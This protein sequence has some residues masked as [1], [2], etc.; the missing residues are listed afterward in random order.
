[1]SSSAA[2]EAVFALA[3]TELSGNT[4][5]SRQD[6]AQACVEA[7][8]QIAGAPTG[9]MDQAAVLQA[10]PGCALLVDASSGATSQVPFDLASH[11]LELLIIDTRAPHALVD[12]EYGLRRQTCERV[13]KL[14]GVPNLAQ[15][16][17]ADL[18]AAIAR[19]QELGSQAA[20][21]KRPKP[22][23]PSSTHP[24]PT[25]I[26]TRCLHHARL[27][28]LGS[29][30]APAE[31]SKAGAPSST[32]P[33]STDTE[34]RRLHHARLQELGSQ[35]APGLQ[36]EPG[37]PSSMHPS[38]MDIETRCLRHVVTEIDRTKQFVDLLSAGR[39][40]E[41]GPLLSASHASLRDDYRVSSPELDLAAATAEQA[42]ALGAR[43]VGG[44]FGGSA[45]ALVRAGSAPAIAR[46]VA[47][48][49]AKANHRPPQFL[50]ATPSPPAT[51]LT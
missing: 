4:Q 50:M 10:E 14:L 16:G 38:P 24:S 31:Q 12:S 13:A 7:E 45:L 49:F 44:G 35:A 40:E 3:S 23:A 34:R 9:G 47:H 21:A 43:M 2:L 28:E 19:L 37:A 39:V 32:H 30:A 11:G 29:Q 46:A 6:L 26:E 15:I 25:D 36:P 17:I 20:P 8:N 1:L 18:P 33:S 51:R 5:L 27:Q 42:G 22:G 48:Q 41:V